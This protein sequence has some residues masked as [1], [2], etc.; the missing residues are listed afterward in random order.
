MCSNK[1][2]N[3]HMNFCIRMSDKQTLC[4]HSA[5]NR[6]KWRHNSQ[7]NCCRKLSWFGGY[8]KARK[9]SQRAVVLTSPPGSQWRPL[10][11]FSFFLQR[12][13][14][15]EGDLPSSEMTSCKYTCRAN[16]GF[17]WWFTW[18]SIPSPSPSPSPSWSEQLLPWRGGKP[19]GGEEGRLWIGGG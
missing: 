19:I 5:W 10:L 16:V 17:F 11:P 7:H 13:Q 2:V 14:V 12:R 1:S 3:P 4:C 15:R 9:K 6:G 18:A 8:K